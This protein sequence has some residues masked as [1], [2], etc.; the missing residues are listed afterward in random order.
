MSPVSLCLI[1]LFFFSGR[2]PDLVWF[3]SVYLG[4]TAGLVADQFIM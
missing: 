4:T 2:V 3:G 1:S